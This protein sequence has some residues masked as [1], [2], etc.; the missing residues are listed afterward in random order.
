MRIAYLFVAYNNPQLLRR[1]IR[2]LSDEASGFFVHIDKKSDIREFSHICGSNVVFSER[3]VA[4]HW[5]GFAHV[6]A[7]LCL[8]R[9][10]MDSTDGFDYCVLQSGSDYPLRSSRYIQS[11]FTENRGMEFINIAKIPSPEAGAPLSKINRV[12]FDGSKPIRQTVSRGLA[13]V[14]FAR[15]DYRKYL[16][17]LVPF[18]GDGWW[19]LTAEACRYILNFSERNPHI[20]EYFRTTLAPDE[21]FFHTILGNS[22][23]AS[24]I[25]RGLFYLDWSAGGAHPAM[26][27]EKHVASFEAQDRILLDD[28]WGAGEALF[29]RK[30]SDERL[31]LVDRIEDMI[32]RKD[33]NRGVRGAASTVG[34]G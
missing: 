13:K 30:F 20:A 25:R 14:G 1:E 15:R 16:G 19:A 5:G 2:M 18:A 33:G 17:T 26:I 10:A 31:E 29:T 7:A 11:F 32:R 6:E 23:F 12:W 28:V 24:R 27:N 21:M 4:V 8:L 3:R 9:K 22:A 34:T